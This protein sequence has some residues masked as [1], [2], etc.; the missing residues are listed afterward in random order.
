MACCMVA[1]GCALSL[2]EL[3]LWVSFSQYSVMHQFVI[4]LWVR[5]PHLGYCLSQRHLDFSRE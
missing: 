5:M 4:T 1:S 3:A 2:G